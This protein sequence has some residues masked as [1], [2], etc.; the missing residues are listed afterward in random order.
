MIRKK[1]SM[2]VFLIIFLL[3]ICTTPTPAENAEKPLL[4]VDPP[5]VLDLE[6]C[7]NFTIEVKIA[8]I[9]DLYG[10]DLKLSWDPSILEYV[11]HTVMVPVETHPGGVLHEPV[12]PVKDKVDKDAG[13]YECA[14]SQMGDTPTFNGSGTIF[15]MTFHVVGLGNCEIKFTYYKFVDEEAVP[16]DIDVQNGYFQ[17]YVPPPPPPAKIYVSPQKI[18]DSTLQVC[19]NFS[20]S[21]KVSD[22]VDLYHFELW[23]SYNT[24]ILDVTSIYVNETFNPNIETEIFESEGLLRT[25]GWLTP[26]SPSIE[27]SAT[28][29][30]IT[31]HVTGIGESVLDVFNVT[32]LNSASEPIEFLEPQDGYFNNILKAKIFVYPE[33]LISPQF[34]PGSVFNISIMV[35]DAMDLYSYHFNL[36][37]DA[38][39]LTCVGVFIPPLNGQYN[40]IPEVNWDEETGNVWINVTYKPPAEPISVISPAA[41]ANIYFVIDTFGCTSLA[42]TDSCLMNSEGKNIV[43]EVSDG[44]FC[45]LIRDI[46]IIDVIPS[47]NA[48]YVGRPVQINVTVHNLGDVSESFTVT[49]YY[50][51]SVIGTINVT[52]LAPK[53]CITVT[54]LWDTSLLNPCQKYVISA[55]VSAVPYEIDLSNNRFE[56]RIVKIKM[57]GDING[58][59]IIDISDIILVA[60]IYDSTE[61]D[62]NWNPDADIAAPYGIIDI[63]DLVTIAAKYGQSCH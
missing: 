61:A 22:I 54:F 50:N 35:D 32:L 7:Q 15:S 18:I 48:T 3:S 17:N 45:T 63:A 10:F 36:S 59:G 52:E 40:F 25:A 38:S 24:T 28:L 12:L 2:I 11:S 62:P 27:G 23:M 51:E 43:H 30:Y 49:A 41:I 9:T 47:R 56:G 55:E 46:A 5:T 29:V 8:N 19:K 16:L 34:K 13:I 21:I 58:D 26:P 60:S 31:F 1:A 37:Y 20:I 14:Y 53:K 42:I 39:V 4:Y 44:Y 33:T 6:P 57:L